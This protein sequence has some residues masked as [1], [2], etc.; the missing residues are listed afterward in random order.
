MTTNSRKTSDQGSGSSSGG[1]DSGSWR[2]LVPVGSETR[3]IISTSGRPASARRYRELLRLL[4]LDV[5]YIPF[6]SPSKVDPQ[7]FASA[8]RGLHALGGA[9]SKD[10]K[11]S[12]AAHLDELD[13]LARDIGAVNTV[14]CRKD[15]KLVGYN[16]DAAG[17]EV[18][19]REGTAGRTVKSAV[20]Y[21]YGGVTAC[22]V[23]VLRKMKIAVRITGRRRDAAA[24]R[25]AELGVEVFDAAKHGDGRT[26]LFVNAAPVTD[27]PLG[28]AAGFLDALA[29]CR[30]AFDHELDGRY[31]REWCEAR[32]V[33][34]IPG[35]SM[36]YPQMVA[37]W[38]LLLEGH[39][40]ETTKLRLRELIAEAEERARGARDGGGGG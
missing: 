16:T 11:G 12:I 36:Y 10:I 26:D 34:H 3:Y 25:A 33:V 1:S 13:P 32:E 27:E 30:V 23:A 35:K 14:V 39:V 9:I 24:S 21:G 6:S 7:R 4:E 2:V 29:G 18:A 38:Q 15:G 22:V 28:G 17:F 5:A 31:L 20:V 8:L 37:Q 19:I 40:D